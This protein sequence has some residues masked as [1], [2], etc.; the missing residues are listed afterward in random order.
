MNFSLPILQTAAP[1]SSGTGQ[2]VT[3]F[4]TFGL[5][6]LVF[7]F[8]IIRPQGKKQKET[9]KMLESIQ[10]G[11]KIVTIGGIHGT[12]QSVKDSSVI[13]RVDENTKLE[14]SRSAISSVQRGDEKAT[15]SE[16][17]IEDRQE[18]IEK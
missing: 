9:K 11:D 7:Y 13:V 10:K 12:I 6:I 14:F 18:K 4:V 3:T 5:V 16:K 15:D 2:L 1:A 17:K 8:L